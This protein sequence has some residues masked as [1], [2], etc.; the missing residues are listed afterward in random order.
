MKTPSLLTTV[1]VATVLAVLVCTAAAQA[2][3]VGDCDHN[4][5]VTV[6]E[7]IRGVNIALA[8]TPL[9]DCPAFDSDASADVTVNE[10]IIA[11][12]IALNGC[13]TPATP[14]PTVTPTPTE[15]PTP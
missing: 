10:L 11:V 15:S 3:C 5:A 12:N 4:G 8:T 9:T 7:L 1:S 2:Q 6:D 13:S 14:T